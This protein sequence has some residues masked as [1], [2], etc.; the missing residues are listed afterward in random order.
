MVRI[1]CESRNL[2]TLN[3]VQPPLYVART[4]RQRNLEQDASS[5]TSAL[6]FLAGYTLGLFYILGGVAYVVLTRTL[7]AFDWTIVA[8]FFLVGSFLLGASVL[9]SEDKDRDVAETEVELAYHL[10]VTKHSTRN[11]SSKSAEM[12]IARLLWVSR[13]GFPEDRRKIQPLPT[14]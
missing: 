7:D 6:K 1:P 11:G 10:P 12:E 4:G 5:L 3:I 13:F 8:S 14:N 2:R 9:T